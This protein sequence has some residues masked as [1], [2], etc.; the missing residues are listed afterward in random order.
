MK[1]RL[2]LFI[3]TGGKDL[4]ESYE[5]SL[6]L[7]FFLMSELVCILQKKGLDTKA[8]WVRS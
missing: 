2:A 3:T 6:V 8:L 7:G 5:N 4:C 1:N